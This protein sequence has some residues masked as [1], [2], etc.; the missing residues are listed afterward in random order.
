MC[1]QLREA[2]EFRE[3]KLKG[4]NHILKSGHY[5]LKNEHKQDI[6]QKEQLQE[7]VSRSPCPMSLVLHGDRCLHA[8]GLFVILCP[9]LR[10]CCCALL[11]CLVCVALPVSGQ[12][13]TFSWLWVI[14]HHAR[15]YI[16]SLKSALHHTISGST[17]QYG[18]THAVFPVTDVLLCCVV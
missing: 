5:R 16:G 17:A 2:A 3:A 12:L 9:V 1:L 7:Q 10:I 6:I 14:T 15:L 11:H 18:C 4:K 8:R 13:L